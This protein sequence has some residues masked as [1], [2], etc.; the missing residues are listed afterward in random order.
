MAKHSYTEE[1]VC[2]FINAI[3]KKNTEL[4]TTMLTE[5]PDLVHARTNSYEIHAYEKTPLHYAVRSRCVEIIGDL[6]A[7]GADVNAKTCWKRTPLHYAAHSF[8]NKEIVKALLVAGAEGNVKDHWGYA[9]KDI[10]TSRGN[11][12]IVQILEQSLQPGICIK[13]GVKVSHV[14]QQQARNEQ[15]V[16]SKDRDFGGR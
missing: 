16:A 4:V 12:L 3:D 15:A 13:S 7:A 2:E 8:E 6:L 11:D 5:Y 9:P 1:Q 10:A 14:L